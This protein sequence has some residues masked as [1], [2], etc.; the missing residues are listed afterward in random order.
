MLGHTHLE[1]GLGEHEVDNMQWGDWP[2]QI[3]KHGE[4]EGIE[5]VVAV[6]VV[7][8][9]EHLWMLG[10]LRWAMKEGEALQVANKVGDIMLYPH[11]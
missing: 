4:E 10:G 5:V 11:I 1:C 9:V 8:E 6:L 7:A 2:R 3:G